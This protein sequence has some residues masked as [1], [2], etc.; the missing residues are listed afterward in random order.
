MCHTETK[1]YHCIIYNDIFLMKVSNFLLG[2][3]FLTIQDFTQE[4]HFN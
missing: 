2:F 3:E 4:C 1:Q